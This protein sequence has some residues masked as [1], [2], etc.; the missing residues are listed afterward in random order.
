MQ[1]VT[2]TLDGDLVAEID[3]FIETRAYQSRSEALRD[4]VRSGLH[5]AYGETGGSKDCVAA[6]VYVYDHDVRDLAKRLAD[7]RR[8]HHD[9]TI[10]TTSVDLGHESS[11]DVALLKGPAA[12]V[13]RFAEKVIA[14]RGVRHG[15]LTLV[16]VEIDR[17]THAHG[18]GAHLHDHYRVREA[19]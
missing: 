1:R 15:R 16:P 11:L 10:A 3:R 7:A 14:E 2:V 6:L 13:R 4:L 9:L 5:Q 18:S 12:D 17:D 19:G 8:H